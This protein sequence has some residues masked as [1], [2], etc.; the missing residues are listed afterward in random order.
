MIYSSPVASS[1]IDESSDVDV[2]TVETPVDPKLHMNDLQQ[3]KLNMGDVGAEGMGIANMDTCVLDLSE[4][5]PSLDNGNEE[6]EVE[7]HGVRF[8]LSPKCL[9]LTGCVLQ[10][11]GLP[12]PVE[13][14]LL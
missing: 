2:E 9:E 5:A 3:L 13:V 10:N 11:T 6:T 12:T 4:D 1:E 14:H 7:N 8:Q